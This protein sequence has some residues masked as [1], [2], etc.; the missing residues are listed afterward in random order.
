MRSNG[1]ARALRRT[2]RG[3]AG[4]SA[5][6]RHLLA[7]RIPARATQENG[8]KPSSTDRPSGQPPTTTFRLDPTLPSTTSV[9]G[10][11]LGSQMSGSIRTS[12]PRIGRRVRRRR[13]SPSSPSR[14]ATGSSEEGPTSPTR[15]RPRVPREGSREP[16]GL[17]SSLS[18]RR[19]PNAS[20]HRTSHAARSVGQDP[21]SPRGSGRKASAST[22]PR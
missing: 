14:R 21:A 5:A 19:H 16:S 17:G 7:D 8:L 2:S 22:C 10:R 15:C 12:W 20:A 4:M 1:G 6:A 11:R 9:G 18:N 13:C 3:T